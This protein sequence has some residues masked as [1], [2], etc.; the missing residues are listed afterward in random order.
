MVRS[1][2]FFGADSQSAWQAAVASRWGPLT[3]FASA[4]LEPAS[5]ARAAVAV[6]RSISKA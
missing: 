6:E 5:S 2:S 1:A 3:G 4:K